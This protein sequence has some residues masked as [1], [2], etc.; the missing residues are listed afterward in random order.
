MPITD[1][2]NPASH[3]MGLIQPLHTSFE[4]GQSSRAT[5]TA[6]NIAANGTNTTLCPNPPK[7]EL[8]YNGALGFL[9]SEARQNPAARQLCEEVGLTMEPPF[10]AGVLQ[11]LFRLEAIN[12]LEDWP[13]L[14]GKNNSF[15]LYLLDKMAKNEFPADS[16]NEKMIWEMRR[17]ETAEWQRDRV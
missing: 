8:D 13:L 4:Y 3:C 10:E 12:R 6:S 2:N 5:S 16:E 15:I 7:V 9:S 14:F 11:Y 17:R 1:I